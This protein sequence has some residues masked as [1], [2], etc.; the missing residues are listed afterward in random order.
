MMRE[1]VCIQET[2]PRKA[3]VGRVG[4][5]GAGCVLKIIDIRLS[6]RDVWNTPWVPKDDDML[7]QYV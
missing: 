5:G 3:F 2:L 7:Y 4:G 1:S 6:A